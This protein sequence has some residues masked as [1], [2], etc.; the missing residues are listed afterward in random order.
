MDRGR[1]LFA[2]K[3]MY[4]RESSERPSDVYWEKGR[5]ERNNNM[6]LENNYREI[7]DGIRKQNVSFA[8]AVRGRKEEV[9]EVPINSKEKP[10][11]QC[12]SQKNLISI[13]L[14]VH[15]EASERRRKDWKFDCFGEIVSSKDDNAE[16]ARVPMESD[17]EDSWKNESEEEDTFSTSAEEE[18]SDQFS[19][20][21]GEESNCKS[22]SA[23]QETDVLQLRTPSK[24]ITH[25]LEKALNGNNLEGSND[26]V[27]SPLTIK[28]VDLDEEQTGESRINLNKSP[29]HISP[30]PKKENNPIEIPEPNQLVGDQA[31]KI[32]PNESEVAQGGKMTE[33]ITLE[34]CSDTLKLLLSRDTPIKEKLRMVDK[35]NKIDQSE[36]MGDTSTVLPTE[37]CQVPIRF[38]R[39]QAK[40][41]VLRSNLMCIQTTEESLS[42]DTAIS[43]GVSSRIDEIGESCGFI[44]DKRKQKGRIQRKKSRKGAV[45]KTQ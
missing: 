35:E 42:E 7:S 40:R 25:D 1:R 29:I 4:N 13:E 8:D 2:K 36:A 34:E 23:I 27:H 32:E 9:R 26:E 39:S 44:N 33:K 30:L 20:E 16:E 28:T 45:S 17:K 19:D 24:P 21:E 41:K 37:V 3:A 18:E 22:E 11:Q 31:D 14:E 10:M 12:I 5:V 43:T 15:T 38:T 6:T